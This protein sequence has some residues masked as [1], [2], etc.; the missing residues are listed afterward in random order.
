MLNFRFL[1]GIRQVSTWHD[2]IISPGKRPA[3][4]SGA[5]SLIIRWKLLAMQGTVFVVF[6]IITSYNH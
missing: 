4:A 1:T 6:V 3:T 5:E 2:C